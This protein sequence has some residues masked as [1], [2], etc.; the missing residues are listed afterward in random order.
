LLSLGTA[1]RVEGIEV[2]RRALHQL[3]DLA[4]GKKRALQTVAIFEQRFLP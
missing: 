3:L 1:L 4:L 2:H